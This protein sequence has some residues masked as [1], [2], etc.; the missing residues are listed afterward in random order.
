LELERT[1]L[2]GQMWSSQAAGAAVLG[3]GLLESCAASEV[4]EVSSRVAITD[5]KPFENTTDPSI[6]RL[7]G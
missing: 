6:P 5:P 2:E 3:A 4:A 7:R 1:G